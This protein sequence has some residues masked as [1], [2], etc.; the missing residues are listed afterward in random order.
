MAKGNFGGAP[1]SSGSG[2]DDKQNSKPG[3]GKNFMGKGPF[4]GKR[5]PRK[6]KK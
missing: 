3:N 4:G 5:A 6:P 2:S 1:K